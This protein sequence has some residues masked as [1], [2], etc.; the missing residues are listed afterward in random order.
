M[1]GRWQLKEEDFWPEESSRS[2]TL[3][4]SAASAAPATG[5]V[6]ASAEQ[7]VNGNRRVTSAAGLGLAADSASVFGGVLET[8]P[9]T[10]SVSLDRV[11]CSALAS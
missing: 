5:G 3:V 10:R 9:V 2:P 8:G 6:C 7:Q 11:R 4:L 1:N